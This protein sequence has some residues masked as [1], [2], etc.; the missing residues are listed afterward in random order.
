M[1]VI[2]SPWNTFAVTG[3]A[4]TRTTTSA[5]LPAGAYL[6]LTMALTTSFA[7]GLVIITDSAGG[8]WTQIHTTTTLLTTRTF[9]RT[10]PGTGASI[11]VTIVT[12]S[13]STC[14]MVGTYFTGASGVISAITATTGTGTYPN[15]TTPTAKKSGDLY[16]AN[17][18]GNT[19]AL[20]TFTPGSGWTARGTATFTGSSRASFVQ[21]RLATSAATTTTG[22]VTSNPP[23]TANPTSLSS[24]VVYE[25]FSGWGS[26]F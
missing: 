20:T 1:P 7:S 14:V 25:A 10:T 8:T 11:T 16:V 15:L 22:V 18:H 5:T 9:W 24:F 26:S 17:I 19:N 4:T 13:S 6:S 12:S 21:T 3:S 2:A 23:P